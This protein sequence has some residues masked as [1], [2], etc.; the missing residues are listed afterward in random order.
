MFPLP[1]VIENDDRV[2]LSLVFDCIVPDRIGVRS[3]HLSAVDQ[4]REQ[5][6]GLYRTNMLWPKK[7]ARHGVPLRSFG[8]CPASRRYKK[9]P[10]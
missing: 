2:R 10:Q 7:L 5:D 6:I 3:P 1:D 8:E 4:C 9:R